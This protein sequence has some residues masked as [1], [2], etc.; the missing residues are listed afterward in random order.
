MYWGRLNVMILGVVGHV[1][2]GSLMEKSICA[3]PS[4]EGRIEEETVGG[5][6][7]E[8]KIEGVSGC[9]R[10]C[11]F[12]FSEPKNLSRMRARSF[13]TFFLS[14]HQNTFLRVPFR[15]S[16]HAKQS[17]LSIISW[18]LFYNPLNPLLGA[19]AQMGLVSQHFARSH[20]RILGGE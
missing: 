19:T 5:S 16:E 15:Y 20:L 4:L 11:T 1:K 18:I 17:T 2:R 14:N 12:H 13:T 7:M 10:A 6:G 8:M 3:T 9:F